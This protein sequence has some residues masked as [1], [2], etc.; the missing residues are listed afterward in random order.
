[1]HKNPPGNII[2]K[3]ETLKAFPSRLEPKHRC[4]L[5]L[6][7]FNALLKMLANVVKKKKKERK[8]IRHEKEGERPVL[9]LTN[10][11]IICIEKPKNLET[12]HQ[13]LKEFSIV[14][15]PRLNM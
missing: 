9:S 15:N 5:L 12:N 13:N 6:L 2:V 3:S 4:S 14:M 7:L 11:I 1:M 10:D 8:D